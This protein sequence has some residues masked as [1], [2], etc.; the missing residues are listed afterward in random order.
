MCHF[1]ILYM[2][3]Y[4]VPLYVCVCVHVC[5]CMGMKGG[6]GVGGGGVEKEG[7]RSTELIKSVIVLM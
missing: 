3:V 1:V 4:T 2:N 7:F 6:E 5:V